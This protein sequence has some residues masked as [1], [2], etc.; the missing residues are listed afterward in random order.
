ME[1][2]LCHE[3][4]RLMTS[5]KERTSAIGIQPPDQCAHGGECVR[6][7]ATGF[8]NEFGRHGHTAVGKIDGERRSP[9][10][11]AVQ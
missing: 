4:E 9:V 8:Y 3:M 6:R 10:K 11:T 1:F 2:I 5:S 7:I